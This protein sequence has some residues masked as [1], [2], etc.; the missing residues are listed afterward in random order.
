M[1]QHAWGSILKIPIY[2]AQN[3][4]QYRKNSADCDLKKVPLQCNS[5]RLKIKSNHYM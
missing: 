1:W 2:G 5:V 3:E 4:N